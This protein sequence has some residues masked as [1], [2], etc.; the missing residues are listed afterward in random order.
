MCQ[1][2]IFLEYYVLNYFI[3]KSQDDLWTAEMHHNIVY[4]SKTREAAKVNKN[5]RII[6]QNSTLY[7]GILGNLEDSDIEN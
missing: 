1:S 7:D 4:N 2:G 6:F 3:I 5:T